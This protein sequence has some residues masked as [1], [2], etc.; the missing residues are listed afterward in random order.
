M[1]FYLYSPLLES[2]TA[3]VYQAADSTLEPLDRVLESFLQELG[4]TKETAFLKH[5]LPPLSFRR[6][7]AMLGLLN[8]CALGQAHP[9]LCA[10]FPAVTQE[11]AAHDTRYQKGRHSVTVRILLVRDNQSKDFLL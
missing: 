1:L 9:R 4:V 2:C 8:K 11:R 10:L 5:N 6:D 7:E 3:A